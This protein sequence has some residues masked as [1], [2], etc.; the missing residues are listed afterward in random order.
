MDIGAMTAEC[1]SDERFTSELVALQPLVSERFVSV[2]GKL[3]SLSEQ[4]RS[5]ASSPRFSIHTCRK[6][7]TAIPSPFEADCTRVAPSFVRCTPRTSMSCADAS[8]ND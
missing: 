8:P 3:I 7:V 4:G 5:F 2:T 6:A 1:G